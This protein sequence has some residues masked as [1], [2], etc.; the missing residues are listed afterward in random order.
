MPELMPMPKITIVTPSF[1]Q[2]RFLEETI[3]S[4]LGQGYPNL[5]YI[6][7]DG[8]STDNS[9]DIIRKYAAH[10]AHWQSEKDNGQAAAINAG[11]ARATGDI[12]GWL[13]S[14]DLY[15]PGALAHAASHLDIT[16][17]Q[18]LCGNCFHFVQDNARSFGTDIAGDHASKNLLIYD[19]VNQPS[20]FWTRKTWET[21]GTLN[22]SLHFTFDWDWFIRA[23]QHPAAYLTTAKY[24]SMYRLHDAHKTGSGGD[25]RNSELAQIMDRYAGEKYARFFQQCCLNRERLQIRTQ[26]IHRAHLSRLEM[27]LLRL[28]FREMLSGFTDA[29]IRQVR[30]IANA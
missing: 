1:N 27:R 13:N 19:Y 21:V 7:M 30:T 5:E 29:E 18:L 4:V 11:F 15:L 9:V 26:Q 17:N 20:T 24:L 8:G 22:E 6:I 16:Q 10:L 28:S 2:G 3:T 23:Y 14:D 12:L 25:R